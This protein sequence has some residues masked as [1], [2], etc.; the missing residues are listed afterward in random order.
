MAVLRG[1]ASGRVAPAVTTTLRA[2]E[3]FG[4]ACSAS[5]GC[6]G[7][8]DP[9]TSLTASSSVAV[10]APDGLTLPTLCDAVLF[11]TPLSMHCRACAADHGNSGGKV[12]YNSL[13]SN[14]D[15]TL[16]VYTNPFLILVRI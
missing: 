8:G 7:A 5:I 11:S 9:P 1:V 4:T 14:N 13:C 2:R 6:L 12:R 10:V 15:S 3:E 16:R